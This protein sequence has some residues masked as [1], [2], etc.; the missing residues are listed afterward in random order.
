MEIIPIETFLR[1]A[2]H[3]YK[4]IGNHILND[5]YNI[6]Y[7]PVKYHIGELSNSFA[8]FV[9]V[10][11]WTTIETTGREVIASMEIGGGQSIFTTIPEKAFVHSIQGYCQV[12]LSEQFNKINKDFVVTGDAELAFIVKHRIQNEV[13][14]ITDIA[15]QVFGKKE[16][17]AELELVVDPESDQWESLIFRCYLKVTSDEFL[18]YQKSFAKRFVSQ[19]EPDKR[20]YFSISIEPV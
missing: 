19:I 10:G 14:I 12:F 9:N 16:Y 8:C 5:Y 1:A 7:D 6:I 20:N 13:G 3:N 4:S 18:R 17:Q 11:G 2:S 15:K